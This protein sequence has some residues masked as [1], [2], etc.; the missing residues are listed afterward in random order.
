[1]ATP[2][3]VYEFLRLPGGQLALLVN[4]CQTAVSAIARST[5]SVRAIRLLKAPLAPITNFERILAPLMERKNRV[6]DESRS[7]AALRDTL[8]RKSCP[9]NCG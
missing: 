5:S 1:M 7:L 4:A 2:R 3:Y 9:A 6:T 8:L